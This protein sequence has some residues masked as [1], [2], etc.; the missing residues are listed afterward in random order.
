ML[1]GQNNNTT[2]VVINKFSRKFVPFKLGEYGEII[3]TSYDERDTDESCY[4]T[5]WNNIYLANV[6]RKLEGAVA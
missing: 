3:I 1:T 5:T 6:K 4:V 2:A